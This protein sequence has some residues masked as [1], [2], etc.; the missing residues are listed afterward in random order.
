[1]MSTPAMPP[2]DE[3]QPIRT[4][5]DA[6]AAHADQV[7]AFLRYRTISRADAEDLGQLTFERALRAWPRFDPARASARTWLLAIARNLLIDQHRRATTSPRPEPF[8]SD[9]LDIA[10]GG[11]ELERV[12]GV[13]P[14]LAAALAALNRRE[15]EVIALRFGGGLENPEIADLCGLSLANT[16]Q[17][18]SRSLRKLRA[19]LGD[20]PS[21][22]L[23]QR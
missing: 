9:D 14:E 7:L 16:Q 20:D 22:L 8:D 17:I 11:N 3:P 19:L 1:M 5:E 21:V 2:E 15:R 23:E 18:V 12:L 10:G 4:F 13:S 6:Y